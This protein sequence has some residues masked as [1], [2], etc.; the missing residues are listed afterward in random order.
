MS[1]SGLYAEPLSQLRL[2]SHKIPRRAKHSSLLL[3][4]VNDRKLFDNIGS[5]CYSA[6]CSSTKSCSAEGQSVKYHSVEYHSAKCHSVEYHSARYHSSECHS[7][8]YHPSECH[9]DRNCTECDSAKYNLV[10]CYSGK[11]YSDI[12]YW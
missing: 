11:H 2:E 6:Q 5:C 8:G 9:S 3:K 4:I 1:K 7:P 10:E 12:L